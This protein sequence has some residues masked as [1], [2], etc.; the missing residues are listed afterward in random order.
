[1]SR[2][3]EHLG[4]EERVEIRGQPEAA[5]ERGH[6]LLDLASAPQ[7]CCREHAQTDRFA[8][9]QRSESSRRLE[10]V[11]DGM[12]QVQHATSPL[13]PLVVTD[14]PRLERNAPADRA[15]R[16]RSVSRAQRLGVSLEGRDRF[17][18]VDP[19]GLEDLTEPR[20]PLRDGQRLQGLDVAE[21]EA[22]LMECTHHVLC[23]GVVDPG[24]STDGAIDHR[25]E[26]SRHLTE[27]QP[28]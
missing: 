23:A 8:V 16:R 12:T 3:R 24:L 6:A 26:R 17:L 1:M 27:V 28:T 10:T 21:H 15:R 2:E 5:Q 13:L 14:H 4:R 7:P 25:Q 18:P 22:R 20:D 9:P 11:P 19:R